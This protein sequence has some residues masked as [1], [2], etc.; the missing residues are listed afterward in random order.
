[1]SILHV[2]R[3]DEGFGIKVDMVTSWV[4]VGSWI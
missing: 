2:T 4:D 1:M 3:I